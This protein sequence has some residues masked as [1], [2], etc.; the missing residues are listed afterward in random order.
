MD[1][2]DSC[3]ITKQIESVDDQIAELKQRIGKFI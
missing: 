3:P 2:T 1:P